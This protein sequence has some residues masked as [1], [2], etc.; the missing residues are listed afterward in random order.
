MKKITVRNNNIIW[1]NALHFGHD[2]LAD[3]D[4][5]LYQISKD[6]QD[7]ELELDSMRDKKLLINFI[8]EGHDPR[9]VQPLIKQ[10]NTWPVLDRVIVF[11]SSV[12]TQELD[13]TAWSFDDLMI[14]HGGWFDRIK[15]LDASLQVDCKF[16]CLMRRPSIS[17]ARLANDLLNK[18]DSMQLS[19]GCMSTAEVLTEY[20]AHIPNH[21][22]PVIVDGITDRS[23]GPSEHDQTSPVFRHCL[24]NIVV[25]SSSQTDPGI[26]RSIFITEKTFKAFGLRQIPIWVAVPGLVASVRAMGFD[27]FDDIIDHSYDN[28]IDEDLR[29][30]SVVDQI[31]KLN[32]QFDLD[33]CQTLRNSLQ[34][35]LENNYQLLITRYH[36]SSIKFNNMLEQFADFVPPQLLIFGDSWPHGDELQIHDVAYGELLAQQL[37]IAT[38]KNYSDPGTGI[39]HMILQL[40]TAIQATAHNTG[41]KIAVFFLSGQERHLCYCDDKILNLNIRGPRINPENDP[42]MAEILNNT[43]YKYFYS[44][45]MRDFYMN[46]NVLALQSMCRHHNIEDYYIAGWQQFNFW[47]EVDLER[48]YDQGRTSCRELLNMEFDN[49]DGVVFNNMY[50]SPNLSHP[51][52]LGHQKIADCLFDWIK[53]KSLDTSLNN[54]YNSNKT[55]H[56]RP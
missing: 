33:Q 3:P 10:L 26:W 22:L 8:G 18:V 20:H 38:V 9:T 48:I 47:P 32:Q 30:Q 43:Y 39:G 44:D 25:E 16:L 50:F 1:Y 36:N 12:D 53:S 55:G 17:R 2:V 49:R 37:G 7:S 52:Q 42:H 45:Q 13:Y 35:R 28:I 4:R 54:L 11:S 51:N 41:K 5:V 46:T 29:R 6:L 21:A 19:F 56:P 23:H 31:Q 15:V 40:Q 34:T 24:F 14:N 27:M